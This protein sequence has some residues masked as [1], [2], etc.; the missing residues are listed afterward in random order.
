MRITL[1]IAAGVLASSGAFAQDT[2]TRSLASTCANCHGP[3]AIGGGVI[4]DLRHMPPDRHRIF[5]DVVLKGA[6][7]GQGMA[8]FSNV[9]S[10][11]DADAIHA[12]VIARA[13]ADWEK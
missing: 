6:L 10:E 2:A 5:K 1:F 8:N 3:Q 13:N 7:V 9:L 11:A 4:K 12:Y